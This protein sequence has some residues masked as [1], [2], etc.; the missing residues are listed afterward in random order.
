MVCAVLCFAQARSISDNNLR[1]VWFVFQWCQND[2][3][4]YE[5]AISNECLINQFYQCE[6]YWRVALWGSV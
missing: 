4:T 1:I 5:M 2:K 3:N 6:D